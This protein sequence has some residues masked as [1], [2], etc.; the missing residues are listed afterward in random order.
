M[1]TMKKHFKGVAK[2]MATALALAVVISAVSFSPVITYAATTGN[3]T[4][5]TDNAT[6]K[7]GN[8]T[9]KTGNGTVKTG[10]ATITIKS[11]IPTEQSKKS[12]QFIEKLN[13]YSD[14]IK[15]NGQYFSR[16]NTQICKTFRQ[17]KTTIK[18]KKTTGAN[19]VMPVNW[20]LKE[21]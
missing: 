5:K 14:F 16:S 15:T 8:G 13:V 11:G 9:V 6:V 21:M 3:D 4:V 18:K 19:C 17:A 2:G 7:T 20:A 12:M 1:L 10:N